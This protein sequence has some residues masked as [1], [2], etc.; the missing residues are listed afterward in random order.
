LVDNQIPVSEHAAIQLLD[1]TAGLLRRRH[2]HEAEAPRATSKLVGHDPDRLDGPGLLEEFPK[3]LLRGLVGQVT[4]EELRGH[5]SP[6][7]SGRD[8]NA[9]REARLSEGR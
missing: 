4:Y 9:P 5:R 7:A 1:G 8:K 3:V 2:L 6:P